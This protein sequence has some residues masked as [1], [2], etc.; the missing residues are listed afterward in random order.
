[1]APS[2]AP[3]TL[4]ASVMLRPSCALAGAKVLRCF[5]KPALFAQEAQD[6]VAADFVP[7][8][9]VEASVDL[10]VAFADEG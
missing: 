3:R 9:K 7:G 10:A 5:G 4:G 1:M 8:D 6:A 2:V